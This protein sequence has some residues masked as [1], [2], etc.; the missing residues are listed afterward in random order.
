MHTGTPA[1]AT[2]NLGEVES[3]EN[4]LELEFNYHDHEQL[5]RYLRAISARYP[6]LTA[7]YSIGKSV[8]GKLPSII[9]LYIKH[10]D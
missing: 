5:T 8:Q 3:R 4:G 6:A 10:T 1:Q 7:L 2:T 9:R